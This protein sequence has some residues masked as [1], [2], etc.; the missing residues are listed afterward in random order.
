MSSIIH[1]EKLSTPRQQLLA[2]QAGLAHKTNEGFQCGAP[3]NWRTM[4]RSPH[5][6]ATTSPATAANLV[7][8]LDENP[9]YSDGVTVLKPERKM[10]KHD[11]NSR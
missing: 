5:Q 7:N 4:G 1:V 2:D 8:P 6:V 3:G 9:L 10:L 11:N